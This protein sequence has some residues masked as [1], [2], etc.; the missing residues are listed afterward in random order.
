[1]ADKSESKSSNMLLMIQRK[2]TPFGDHRNTLR[3]DW[4]RVLK[5]DKFTTFQRKA[6][7]YPMEKSYLFGLPGVNP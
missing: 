5:S 3:Q 2:S 7:K 1:M 4:F 6:N